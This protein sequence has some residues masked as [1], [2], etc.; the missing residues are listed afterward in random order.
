MIADY[1]MSE[2]NCR[3]TEIID[4]SV[5]MGAYQ[6]DS[7]HIQ[8]FVTKEGFV[9]NEG[10]IQ[11]GSKP[12]PV[13]Y[14]SIRPRASECTNLLVPVCLSASHIAYG[15]I[16]MELAPSVSEAKIVDLQDTSGQTLPVIDPATGETYD[17]LERG[18]AADIDAAVQAAQR[19]LHGPWARLSAA[20]RGRLLMKLSAKVAEHAQEL[21]A[22]EQRDCGKPI[23]QARADALQVWPLFCTMALT[24]KG[25]A[26]STS[27]SSNT[28]CGPL[29]PSSSV[30]GQWRSAAAC[31]I[32]VPTR[33]LP[34][35]LMWSTPGWRASASPTSWP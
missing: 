34:V 25:R 21:A 13:S 26:A 29:P 15:S 23:K 31:W 22:I 35:K 1:V 16:R 8:R 6:M 14:R 20:E 33:G 30:T 2:K 10:D 19:C 11:V 9:R 32:S 27:A 4:D 5:G 17:S 12:Y 18:N 28:I 24:R 7:H 3:R